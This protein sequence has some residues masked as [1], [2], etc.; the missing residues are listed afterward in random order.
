MSDEPIQT[1]GGRTTKLAPVF[2][3]KPNGAQC[4][5][6]PGLNEPSNDCEHI[7]QRGSGENQSQNVEHRF[8]REQTGLI[9]HFFIA[10]NQTCWGM[11][12]R[13]HQLSFVNAAPKKGERTAQY[14]PSCSVKLD[15]SPCQRKIS[16]S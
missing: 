15:E 3:R 11:Y 2:V 6:A 16:R 10:R 1:G 9:P 12:C 13:L 8:R 7:S 4:T 5:V 14:R